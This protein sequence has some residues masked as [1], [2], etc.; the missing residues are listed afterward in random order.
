MFIANHTSM[1]D[2]MM[3]FY[4]A[5]HP[6]V[7]VGKKELQSI[8]VFGF[9]YK[10]ASILVDRG[11]AKSRHAVFARAQQRL[12]SGLSICIFPEG[13]VP[14]DMSIVLDEFKDGAFRLAIEH[15]IPI[16]PMVF[17]D[18]KKRFPYV[19]FKGKPGLL[20]AIVFPEI[21]TQGLQL[22]DKRQLRQS[23]REIILTALLR[24]QA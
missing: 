15:Q 11:D 24:D 19:F 8:P 22:K 1:A 3:M 10:R 21:P 13:L 4:A 14:D 2:I 20:R 23:S 6:F 12:Q 5:R 7:F 9:F 16:V 18:N 17:F